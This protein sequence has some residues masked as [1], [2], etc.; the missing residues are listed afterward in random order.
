MQSEINLLV[1]YHLKRGF[2]HN[3]IY[4]VFNDYR[5][6]LNLFPKHP[7]CKSF[8]NEPVSKKI[9]NGIERSVLSWVKIVSLN[10]VN[11]D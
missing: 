3:S 1:R 4:S 9:L 7:Q 6:N 10:S 8:F 2:D 5:I 11:L